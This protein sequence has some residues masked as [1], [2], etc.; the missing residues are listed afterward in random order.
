MRKSHREAERIIAELGLAIVETYK[1][2]HQTFVLRAPDG[3]TF[4]AQLAHDMSAPRQWHN[5]KSQLRRQLNG[6]S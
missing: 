1:T 2:K 4:R 3:R 5:W 6:R